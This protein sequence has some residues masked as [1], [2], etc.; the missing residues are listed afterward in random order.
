MLNCTQ[1]ISAGRLR[2]EPEGGPPSKGPKQCAVC[3]SWQARLEATQGHDTCSLRHFPT[4]SAQLTR[5]MLEM[6]GARRGFPSSYLLIL[7]IAPGPHVCRPSPFPGST[8]LDQRKRFHVSIHRMHNL[9]LNLSTS[10]NLFQR[11]SCIDLKD[12]RI[13]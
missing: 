4:S 12:M 11:H 6:P 7:H 9:C 1:E 8:L 5:H 3:S 13:Q 10:G 2:T